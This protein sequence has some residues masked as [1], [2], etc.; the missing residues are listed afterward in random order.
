[1]GCLGG[2]VLLA[3]VMAV[4]AWVVV[5]PTRPIRSTIE[6][7]PEPAELHRHVAALTD[8]GGFRS[9]EHPDVLDRAASYIASQWQA[10]GFKVEEQAYE[11]GGV[12]VRNL[13]V[14]YGPD[15]DPVVVVGAHYDVC[16]DQD[17]ADDN[18]S[19]VASMLELARLLAEHRPSIARRLE[20]VAFTLEEPPFFRTDAMGS[21]VHVRSLRQRGVRVSA[22]VCLEMVGYFTD[23]PRSQ[24]FPIPGL[25]LLYPNTGNFVAVVGNLKGRRLTREVKASMAG[26]CAVPVHSINAPALVPGVDLSDHLNYWREGIPAVMITDTAFYRNPNYHMPSDSARTLDYERMAEVVKGLYPAVCS[27]AGG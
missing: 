16:G 14:G 20:L 2:L 6:I 18:A 27:L 4:V 25:G 5:N 15:T 22:M 23:R 19:A 1:M 21:A 3:V 26:A 9:Y 10:A 7:A 12:R 13:V 17:G 8:L 24:R 11:V